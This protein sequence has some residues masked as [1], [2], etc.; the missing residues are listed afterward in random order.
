MNQRGERK[1]LR[2][3]RRAV[4]GELRLLCLPYA[5]AGATAFA[6]WNESLGS[7][8][9]LWMAVLPGRDERIGEAPAKRMEDL[10]AGLADAVF[11]LD[12]RP[13]AIFGH[14]FG[15]L[16][17]FELVRELRRRVRKLPCHFFASG[18]IAPQLIV[19]R[20]PQTDAEI[21][22]EVRAMGATSEGVLSDPELMALVMP[23]LRADFNIVECYTYRDEPPLDL[24]ISVFA[25]T[26][27]VSLPAAKLEAWRAQTRGSFTHRCWPGGHLYLQDVRHELAT[28]IAQIL[29]T[30]STN[31]AGG[32]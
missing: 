12:D 26:G 17:G 29:L 10:V 4:D 27:D 30:N 8:V 31:S 16:V 14:S 13:L 2:R 3:A 5:G 19:A 22:D 18:M 6:R 21:L 28:A 25:G 20:R 15:A 24:P 11:D 1:W 7:A 23:V 32:E 9:E